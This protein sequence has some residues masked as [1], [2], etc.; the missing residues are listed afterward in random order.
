MYQTETMTLTHYIT[1]VGLKRLDGCIYRL[2]AF[3]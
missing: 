1:K 2:L 3:R